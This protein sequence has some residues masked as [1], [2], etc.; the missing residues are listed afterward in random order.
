[1]QGL[2]PRFF[3]GAFRGAE[4]PLFHVSDDLREIPRYA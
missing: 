2:K 4:A 3:G 1:M